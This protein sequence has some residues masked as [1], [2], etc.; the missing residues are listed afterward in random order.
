MFARGDSLKRAKPFINL[1]FSS[2]YLNQCRHFYSL[3]NNKGGLEQTAEWQ[4]EADSQRL[5]K[6]SSLIEQVMQDKI[7][8]EKRLLEL[9]LASAKNRMLAI[10]FG[11]LVAALGIFMFM[12]LRYRRQKAQVAEMKMRQQL[13]NQLH[14]E[15]AAAF[16]GINLFGQLTNSQ[17]NQQNTS[18]AENFIQKIQEHATGMVQRVNDMIWLLEPG[19]DTVRHLVQHLQDHFGKPLFRAGVTC[20]WQLEDELLETILSLNERRVL[21]GITRQI[22]EQCIVQQKGSITVAYRKNNPYFTWKLV[23]TP[24]LKPGNWQRHTQ[25]MAAEMPASCTCSEDASGSAIV[26]SW[27]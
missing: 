27:N 21:H 13:S 18:D 16:S 2:N 25:S 8:A 26:L 7:G 9:E 24:A 20:K 1:L 5:E 10:I 15:A 12:L 4:R 22:L 6:Q 23:V 11:V 17:L 19:H 3:T 14:D